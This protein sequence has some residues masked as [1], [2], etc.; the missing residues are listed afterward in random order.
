M[1]KNVREITTEGGFSCSIEM[2]KLDDWRFIE[3]IGASDDDE[4]AEVKLA[5]FVV[6]DVLS[7]KDSDAL[8]KFCTMPDG[9]VST[10]KMQEQ[11]KEIMTEMQQVKN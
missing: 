9:R 4:L 3:I 11:I 8:K 6:N 10:A 7:K 1:K 2:D 5:L